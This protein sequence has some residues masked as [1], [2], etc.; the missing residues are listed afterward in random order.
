MI[1]QRQAVKIGYEEYLKLR[2]NNRQGKSWGVHIITKKRLVEAKVKYRHC[3]S[4]LD[5]WY[6]VISKNVFTSFAEL[7]MTFN[8]VDKVGCFYVFNIGG[9][10]L[11]IIASIHFNRQKLYIRHVL[12]HKEYDEGNWRNE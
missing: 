3:H 5:A 1:S 11:R 12:T 7:K 6:T 2:Y 10:K 9:N 4:A 8:S